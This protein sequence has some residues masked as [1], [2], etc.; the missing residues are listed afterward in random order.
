[1]WTVNLRLIYVSYF[2]SSKASGP[3]MN[4]Y[5]LT[6]TKALWSRRGNAIQ[7]LSLRDISW[8][9][10]VPIHRHPEEGHPLLSTHVISERLL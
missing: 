5:I 8:I 6:S 4:L 3:V 2:Q 9:Q 1:M 7:C 10:I